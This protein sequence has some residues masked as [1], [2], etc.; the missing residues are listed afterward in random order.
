MKTLALILVIFSAI[1]NFSCGHG[2]ESSPLGANE[3]PFEKPQANPS[4]ANDEEIDV[5][6]VI[7]N[8]NKDNSSARLKFKDYEVRKITVKKREDVNGETTDIYD[9]VLIKNGKT[10]KR[11]EGSYYSLGNEMT[12]GFYPFLGGAEK[13]LLIADQLPRHEHEWIINLT[14]KFEVLFDSEDY[15]VGGGQMRLIDIDKDG[16]YEVFYIEFLTLDFILPGAER[17]E[18]MGTIIF[19]YDSKLRKYLPANHVFTDYALKGFDE[20]VKK[21]NE[22]KEPSLASL[23]QIFTAYVYAG[24]EDEAWSFFEKEGVYFT[25]RETNS[26]KVEGKKQIIEHIKKFLNEDPIYKFVKRDLRK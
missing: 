11:F 7:N 12:L 23:L 18:T 25:A 16:V 6:E 22:N 19:K 26:G 14:P 13:Q 2:V 4:P 9:A 1:F 3:K 10:L 8:E 15:N 17:L 21:F 5:I 24:R 20:K